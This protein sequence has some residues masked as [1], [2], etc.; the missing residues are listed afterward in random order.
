MT[1]MELGP[2][3]TRPGD[4]DAVRYQRDDTVVNL[5]LQRCVS[6]RLRDAYPVGAHDVEV[7]VVNDV[8]AQDIVTPLAELTDAIQA[9]DPQC[10][11]VVFAVHAGHTAM[12]TA[13]QAAGFRHVV[14]VDIPGAEL[15]L[16]VA[17]P[18]WVTRVDADVQHVPGS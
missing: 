4:G 7:R 10:R 5:Q 3:W 6:G 16:L 14:D 15:S 12:L 8:A 9:A 18:Q 11:R 1:R 13:A 17:E 2:H